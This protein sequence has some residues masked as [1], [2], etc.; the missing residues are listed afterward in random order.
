MVKSVQ[1]MKMSDIKH[2]DVLF[3]QRATYKN[4]HRMIQAHYHE[5]HELYYLEKGKTKY[6]IGDE[7]FL[8]EPG[9]M[10]FVPKQVFHKTDTEDTSNVRRLL[11][12][13]DDDFAGNPQYIEELKKNKFIRIPPDKLYKLQNI[14]WQ[15]EEEERQKDEGFAEIQ[16]LLFKQMLI[17]IS[18]YC[19]P[20]NKKLLDESTMFVQK[21]AK[22]ISENYDS[23]LSLDMLSKNFSVSPYHLS[24][25]FKGVTGIGLSEYINI[26]R[27]TAAE[28]LL[29]T[30]KLTVTQVATA[31]GFNDSN[32]FAAVFKKIKGITPKK[33]SMKK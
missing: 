31:C 20:Q 30:K 27:V 5:V 13:F 23:D 3:F 8:L 18:R 14:F 19:S 22:Y 12:S 17:L 2:E 26:C 9:D 1:V 16:K 11:F 21:I 28:K 33:Y 25:M 10:V 29:T 7:I 24:R 32:Y 15:I 4:P 6:F